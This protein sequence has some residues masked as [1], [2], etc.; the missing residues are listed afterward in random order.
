MK[1]IFLTYIFVAI[2]LLS[3]CS[4][5]KKAVEA[6]KASNTD[7]LVLTESQLATLNIKFAKPDRKQIVE[8]IYLNGKV[9]SLPNLS[10]TVSSN[11]EGKVDKIFVVEGSMVRKGQAIMTLSSMELIE[12]Q[13]AYMTAESETDFST[14]ELDRQKELIKN[15][16][17]ALVD[18]QTAEA[19]YNSSLSREKTLKAKLDLLGISITNLQ[20][21]KNA[22]V[23]T[24]VTIESP[25]DGYVINLPVS[26]GVLASVQTV[27]AEIVNVSELHAEIYVYDKDIDLV[28]DGQTVEIDFVNHAL[29]TVKGTVQSISRSIDPETK[30]IEV[31]VTFSA[32]KGAL[33]LPGMS[34]RAIVLNK[35]KDVTAH[36]V[37]LSAV[38]REEDN[39]F[40]F[41]TESAI[42]S[43]KLNI[44]KYKVNLGS[45]DENYTEVIF[46]NEV[47]DKLTIAQN[48]VAAL[49]MQRKQASGSEL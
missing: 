41:G 26:V 13:N 12:L 1:N 30:A 42:G 11:I 2:G 19:K 40:V 43:G 14:I 48:N 20:D 18:L 46:P 25:I 7:F 39:Y 36:A 10:A 16:V 38:L 31:H 27:L 37:P 44:K 6:T 35:D 28:Q 21:P 17:G 4:E 24:A 45:K 29:A 34:V 8:N 3:G 22:N 33:V 49:E 15:N 9:K 47:S 23:A 5:E 32:P